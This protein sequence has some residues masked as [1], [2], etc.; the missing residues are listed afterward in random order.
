MPSGLA[1]T[2]R[3]KQ[4]SRSSKAKSVGVGEMGEV[5]RVVLAAR[6]QLVEQRSRLG[7]I[8]PGQHEGEAVARQCRD[9]RPRRAAGAEHARHAE[10]VLLRQHRR[11]SG[12]RKPGSI[13]VVAGQRAVASRHDRVDRAD[14]SASGSS[15][16]SSGITACLC[17]MVTLH[18]R[19]SRIV[20][21][22]G[23]IVG[24][25]VRLLHGRR[26]RPHR[27]RACSSQ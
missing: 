17:G 10:Q 16:S 18:P 12:S 7:R 19:Q 27:A 9:D 24:Q 20:A 1:L 3:S 26:D 2:T 15:R 11:A 13:G 23:E 6:G 4:P 21:P 22:G 8:A 14:R 25:A 5:D